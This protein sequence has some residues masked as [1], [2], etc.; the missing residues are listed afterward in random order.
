MDTFF[1]TKQVYEFLAD[2]GWKV[3]QRAVYNH[4]KDGKLRKKDGVFTSQA[5]NKY[6]K[7]FLNRKDSGQ[8]LSEEH[9]QLQKQKLTHEVR[10]LKIQIERDEHK[11][12]VE[13]GKYL[14][15]EDFELELAA[16]ASVFD[17]GFRYFFQS[18][19]PEIIVLVGGNIK[20]IPEFIAAMNTK[21][22]EQ[23]NEYATTKEYQV[24]ILGE[25]QGE[26]QKEQEED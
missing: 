24:M 17:A 3:S 10:R 21:L 6:A 26:E 8:M 7:T 1:N 4:V 18:M 11:L 25:E 14:P 12:G 5:V 16:R 9:E 19:A 22:D 13:Q 2:Q 15:R 20:K 23:L